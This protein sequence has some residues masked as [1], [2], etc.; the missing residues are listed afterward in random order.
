MKDKQIPLCINASIT[1]VSVGH[2]RILTPGKPSSHCYDLEW[3]E[4]KKL[5]RILKLRLNLSLGMMVQKGK[6][7][8]RLQAGELHVSHIDSKAFIMSN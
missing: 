3:K 1:N 7:I 2:N 6:D 8:Q 4:I 5:L